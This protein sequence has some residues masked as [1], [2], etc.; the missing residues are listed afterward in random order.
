MTL[1]FKLQIFATMFH[2]SVETTILALI[3]FSLSALWLLEKFYGRGW[4]LTSAWVMAS[5]LF[6]LVWVPVPLPHRVGTYINSVE[7][8]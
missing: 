3:F 8:K 2:L 4:M 7:S 6:V 1:F 5:I